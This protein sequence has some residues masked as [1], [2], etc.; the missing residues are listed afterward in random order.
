[1]VLA[2]LGVLRAH[3]RQVRLGLAV[4]GQGEGKLGEDFQVVAEGA[5]QQARQPL[6]HPGVGASLRSHGDQRPVDEL[7]L[8]VLTE[9]PRFGHAVIL[10]Q[11]DPALALRQVRVPER[12]G[13]R[14]APPKSDSVTCRVGSA[15]GTE[16]TLAGSP[17]A[18]R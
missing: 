10:V 6:D 11:R 7:D 3:D 18:P 9:D 1:M 16:T 15:L 8:L 2:G 17:A 4:V 12:H 13:H 5:H 14:V